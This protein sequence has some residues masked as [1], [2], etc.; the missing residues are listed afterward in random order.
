MVPSRDSKQGFALAVTSN[1]KTSIFFETWSPVV[2]WATIQFVM[3]LAAK[4]CYKSVQCNI[5]EAFIHAFLKPG[6]DVYVNQPHGFKMK[7]DHVLKLKRTCMAFG[8]LHNI[9]SSILPSASY[10]KD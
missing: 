1:M 10:N 4:M 5:T 9:S 7:D 8:K 2:Q 6:E 3:V